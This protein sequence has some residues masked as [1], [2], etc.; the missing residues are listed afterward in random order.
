[1]DFVHPLYYKGAMTFW[2]LASK[3]LHSFIT[4]SSNTLVFHQVQKSTH[5]WH[6]FP[7][8]PNP[9]CTQVWTSQEVARTRASLRLG[10]QSIKNQDNGQSPWEEHFFTNL[11]NKSLWLLHSMQHRST[12]VSSFSAEHAVFWLPSVKI[13]GVGQSCG[14]L[15][16]YVTCSIWW[17]MHVVCLS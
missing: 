1:M 12:E 2:K 17:L 13:D 9:S 14:G 10:L 15:P 11:S 5:F 7:C 4:L 16:N 8:D 6:I 3:M